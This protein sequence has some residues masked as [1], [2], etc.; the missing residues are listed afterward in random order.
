MGITNNRICLLGAKRHALSTPWQHEQRHIIWQRHIY[1]WAPNVSTKAKK[2]LETLGAFGNIRGW[3]P[4]N[5][6]IRG[7]CNKWVIFPKMNFKILFRFKL[8]M[9]IWTFTQK[10]T[11]ILNNYHVYFNETRIYFLFLDV[12]VFS[13][14]FLF[15]HLFA[16]HFKMSENG[17]NFENFTR[18]LG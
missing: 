4:K 10:F 11:W 17:A 6:N 9:C 7:L 13:E 2:S 1:Q 18:F 3:M 5:G 16:F 12:Y 15:I 8:F 14:S